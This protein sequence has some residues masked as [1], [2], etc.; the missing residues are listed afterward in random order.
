MGAAYRAR[1]RGPAGCGGC[2]DTRTCASTG[3][4]TGTGTAV[5]S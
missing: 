4:G 2:T 3:T 1:D 5:A